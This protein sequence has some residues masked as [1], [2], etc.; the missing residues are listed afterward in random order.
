MIEFV[1]LEEAKARDGLRMVYVPGVPSPWGEAAK[2]MLHVKQVP[3]VAVRLLPGDNPVTRWTGQTSAPVAMYGD[4]R[5][6]GGW[7]EILLLFERIAP[8]PAL[9]PADPA[10]RALLFGMLHEIA[11]EMGLGWCRRLQGIETGLRGEGGFPKPVAEYL[12]PKYGWREGCGAEAKRRV[13][14]VLGLLSSRLAAQRERGSRTYLGDG[15]T[16][17]DI[18]S[19]TFV[20]LFAPLPPEQCPMPPAMREGFETLDDETAAAL[21]PAL[22]EHRDFVYAESLELPLCL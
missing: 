17:L 14:E 19:A 3:H 18:Y 5:P 6:R 8:E 7:A 22:L 21:D 15:L 12:A 16:A 1:E 20:A 2:G 10:E 11:G 4:E 13:I 9:I